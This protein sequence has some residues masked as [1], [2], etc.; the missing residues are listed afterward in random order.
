MMSFSSFSVMSNRAK[1]LLL[2]QPNGDA[3]RE[4]Q[5]DTYEIKFKNFDFIVSYCE[6]K[7][8]LGCSKWCWLIELFFHQVLLRDIFSLF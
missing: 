2:K 7:K 3:E 8:V 4:H 1:D 5:I 6:I